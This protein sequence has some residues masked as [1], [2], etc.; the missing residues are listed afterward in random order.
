ME[1]RYG[2][3]QFLRDAVSLGLPTH[4]AFS[5]IALRRQRDQLILQ[6]HPDCGGSAN[7]AW[8]INEIYGRMVKWRDEHYRPGELLDESE[9]EEI[10]AKHHRSLRQAATVAVSA[11]IFVVSGYVFAR[12]TK[13]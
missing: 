3:A 9:A 10:R 12:W 7:K 13:R 2:R 5:R 8:E 11:A 6:H 1:K 4:L